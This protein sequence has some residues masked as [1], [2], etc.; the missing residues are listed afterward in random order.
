MSARSA[1][2]SAR[3][4]DGLTANPSRARELLDRTAM[5]AALNP[6]IGYAASAGLAKE[7]VRTGRPIGDLL[8]EPACS[9]RI[10][11]IG[12]LSPDAMARGGVVGDSR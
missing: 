8:L 1:V 4:V 9:T 6:H 10:G 3:E 5:A 11:S 12:F 7:P 2:V